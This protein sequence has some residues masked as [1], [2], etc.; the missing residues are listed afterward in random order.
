MPTR[1]IT[2]MNCGHVGMLDVHYANEIVPKDRLFKH[3]GHNPYSGDLHYQCPAC[4][5]VLLV[6]PIAALGKISL[7]GFPK[8]RAELLTRQKRGYRSGQQDRQPKAK[9][10]SLLVFFQ[11]RIESPRRGSWEPGLM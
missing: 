1:D 4:E 5:I 11:K 10:L 8:R 3:L 9:R 7:K 6:D 2:C